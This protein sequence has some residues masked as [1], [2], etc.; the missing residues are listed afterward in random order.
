M[1]ALLTWL[2]T[3]LAI[4]SFMALASFA[5]LNLFGNCLDYPSVTMFMYEMDHVMGGALGLPHY[6]KIEGLLLGLAAAGVW[7]SMFTSN[8]LLPVL[9]YIALGTCMAICSLCGIYTGPPPYPIVPFVVVG[10]VSTVLLVYRWNKH[11]DNREDE[12]AWMFLTTVVVA[13]LCL[14]YRVKSNEPRQRKTNARFIQINQWCADHPEFRWV[15]G[16]DAPEGYNEEEK[17][18]QERNDSIDWT[19]AD[20]TMRNREGGGRRD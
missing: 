20:E 8:Q 11:L 17:Q 9:G 19:V 3:F 16:K 2:T 10:L 15:K 6:S 12:T 14:A 13:L 4:C 7:S 5:L 18:Q 1:A